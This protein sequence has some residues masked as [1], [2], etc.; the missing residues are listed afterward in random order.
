MPSPRRENR[1]AEPSDQYNFTYLLSGLLILLLA[2]PLIRELIPDLG[3]LVVGL[4]ISATLL[5]GAWTLRAAGHR[6]RVSVGLA[7]VGIILT[8]L[9]IVV[10]GRGFIL[11]VMV[12]LFL[13]SFTMTGVIAQQV[14]GSGTVDANKIVGAVCIYLLLGVLWGLMYLFVHIAIPGAFNGIDSRYLSNQLSEFIYYSF[15]TL[16]TLGYGD[17]APVNALPRVLAFL[18]AVLGQMYIAVLVASL[19]AIHISNRL[20]AA[21]ARVPS[22]RSGEEED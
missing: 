13:F 18:E 9:D 15:V 16:T 17:M 3:R 14:L 4:I 1:K 12:V 22:S 5:L 6:F 20:A 8:T 2:G 21:E 7:A 19:V 11:G 10:G